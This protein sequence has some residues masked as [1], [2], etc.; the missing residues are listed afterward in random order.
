MINSFDSSL[1]TGFRK[2]VKGDW[3]PY[4]RCPLFALASRPMVRRAASERES[5]TVEVSPLR[6]AHRVVDDTI[7]R[8]DL[9]VKTLLNSPKHDT[10]AL[11]AY[12]DALD[13]LVKLA[14]ETDAASREAAASGVP[15]APGKAPSTGASRGVVIVPGIMTDREE[16]QRQMGISTAR[17]AESAK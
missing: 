7:E 5:A 9:K 10:I 8:L 4:T 6:R 1:R 3:R 13:K 15:G 2:S 17:Q 12:V 14:R 11:N 16:W